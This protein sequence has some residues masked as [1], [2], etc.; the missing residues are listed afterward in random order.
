MNEDLKREMMRRAIELSARTMRAGKGGPFGAVI[1]REGS[2]VAEGWN[3]VTSSN[4]PTAHAEVTAIRAAAAKL[5]AFSLKG[6]DLYTSCEPCPMCLAAAYWARVDHV[7]YANTRDDAAK[8]GFDD[9]M[10]YG[11]IGKPPGRQRLQMV[12][13][14]GD[15]AVRVFD[16][17]ATKPDRQMY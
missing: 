2:V 3:Q 17:W 6:C 11:E 8:I 4:D 14:M 1:A 5:G 16:E 7:Y 13:M 9:S 12:R 10:I 15:E